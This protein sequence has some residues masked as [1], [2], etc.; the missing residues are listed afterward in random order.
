MGDHEADPVD[1]YAGRLCE[2][3][4]DEVCRWCDDI[5]LIPRDE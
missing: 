1:P 2:H 3:P 4:P 5:V